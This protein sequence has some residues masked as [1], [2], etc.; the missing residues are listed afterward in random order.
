MILLIFDLLCS[1][2]IIMGITFPFY[3]ILSTQILEYHPQ[4]LQEYLRGGEQTSFMYPRLGSSLYSLKLIYFLLV[5]WEL[6]SY[7]REKGNK[8]NEFEPIHNRC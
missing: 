3:F 7:K 8:C 2:L 4:M 5:E 1:L 6:L